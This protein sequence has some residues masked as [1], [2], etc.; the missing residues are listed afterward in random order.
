VCVDAGGAKKFCLREK[1]DSANGYAAD[2]GT[3]KRFQKYDVIDTVTELPQ[4]IKT[5]I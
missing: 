2:Y 4:N 3:S 1:G 5:T